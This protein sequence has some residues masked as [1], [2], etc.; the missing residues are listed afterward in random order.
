MSTEKM[1][2]EFEIW[3]EQ[4]KYFMLGVRDVSRADCFFV[5]ESS[6]AA[7][8]F[9]FPKVYPGETVSRVCAKYA[10]AIKAEGLRIK[11]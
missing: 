3:F 1:R 10:E 7:I 2:E 6:R 8:E 5:W 11:T 4:N 9:E